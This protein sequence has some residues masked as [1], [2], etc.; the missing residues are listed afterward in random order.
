MPSLYTYIIP[1]D[2]GAAPNP[3]GGICTLNICKPAIRR[4]AKKGDWIA[5]FGSLNAPTGS[6]TGRMVYAMKVTGKMPMANYDR[7]AASEL[8]VKVPNVRSPVVKERL[9]DSIY[10]FSIRPPN[11]RLGVHE[12]SNQETDLSGENCL[13]SDHFVYFGKNAVE[14]PLTLRA[15]IYQGRGHRRQKNDPYF[16]EF[17]KWVEG[18]IAAG[19]GIQGEPDYE[20]DWDSGC[21][22]GCTRKADDDVD[23]EE[24][25]ESVATGC[26]PPC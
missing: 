6:L 7:H 14:V 22:S 5:A 10:D 1:V 16:A 20:I 15:V 3:F 26:R 24:H 12:R 11:Q 19:G 18:L 2:D 23:E 17:E 13:L 8:P 25:Q 21:S 9:G 4:T